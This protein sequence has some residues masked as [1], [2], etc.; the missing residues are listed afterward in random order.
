MS[1]AGLQDILTHQ[2]LQLALVYKQMLSDDDARAYLEKEHVPA[3]LIARI[4][5]AGV[6]RHIEEAIERH[7]QKTRCRRRAYVPAAIIEAALRIE[8]KLG[9]DMALKLLG[10]EGIAEQTVARV[11]ADGPR[12]VRTRLTLW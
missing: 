7:R 2:H 11:L 12:Q 3:H 8:R 9:R 6:T 4:L 1:Q 5:S 10:N